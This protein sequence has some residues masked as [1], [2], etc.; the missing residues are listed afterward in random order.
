ME[1]A[2]EGQI[3]DETFFVSPNIPGKGMNPSVLPQL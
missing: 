2:A 3:L 1:S